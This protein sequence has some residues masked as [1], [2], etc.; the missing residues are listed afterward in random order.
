M[1]GPLGAG[2]EGHLPED[3]ERH[4]AAHPVRQ[5]VVRRQVVP[6][7]LP[8]VD[9]AAH[10]CW[11]VVSNREPSTRLILNGDPS[12]LGRSHHTTNLGERRERGVWCKWWWVRSAQQI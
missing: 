9:E 2:H 6:Q 11:G 10:M 12:T 1:G 7:V 8:G 5:A 4:G 3:R